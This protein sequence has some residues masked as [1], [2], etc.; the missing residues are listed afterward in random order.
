[1]RLMSAQGT[2]RLCCRELLPLQMH[3]HL[4]ESCPWMQW[5]SGRSP[6]ERALFTFPTSVP[7]SVPSTAPPYHLANSR[8][9]YVSIQTQAGGYAEYSTAPLDNV[10]TILD[11][12][13]DQGAVG[14]FLTSLTPLTLVKEAYPVKRG[15]WVLLNAATR[16]RGATPRNVSIILLMLRIKSDWGQGYVIRS[17]K[18]MVA[19]QR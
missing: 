13:S 3:T 16:A 18:V 2:V 17:R 4:I 8:I 14:G 5:L 10:I 19:A 1:M 15:E 6:L 7:S 9:T 11:T 12:I